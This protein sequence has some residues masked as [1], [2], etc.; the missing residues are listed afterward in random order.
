MHNYIEAEKRYAHGN[1]TGLK[2]GFLWLAACDMQGVAFAL[3][4][5]RRWSKAVRFDTAAREKVKT[6]GGTL[7]GMVQIW[8]EWI[9]NLYRRSKKKWERN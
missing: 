2:Y 3:S 8:D 7:D 1:E 9:D 5:Q 4:G 6:L